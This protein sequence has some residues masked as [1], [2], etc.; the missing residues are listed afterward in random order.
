MLAGVYPLGLIVMFISKRN[1]RIGDYA[2]GT[3][4]IV[5]RRQKIPENRIR[6][7]KDISEISPEIETRISSLGPQQYQILKSFL[8]RRQEMD[9][10]SR[11]ELAGLLAQRLFDR[12]G[13]SAK[14]EISYEIFLEQVVE[15]YERNR[16]AI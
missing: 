11:H 3:V 9:Q 2:A 8:Q 12:W 13:I 15:G 6:L 16:R 10:K 5:E 4:V 7:K 14:I 1:Q